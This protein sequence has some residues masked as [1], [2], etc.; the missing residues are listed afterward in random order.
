ME[1]VEIDEEV[2]V[3][4]SEWMGYMLLYEEAIEKVIEIAA[5]V[6]HLFEK[7]KARLEEAE[8]KWNDEKSAYI[9]M[10]GA[11]FSAYLNLAVHVLDKGKEMVRAYF[12]GENCS[13]QHFWT[14]KLYS[15]RGFKAWVEPRKLQSDK[16]ETPFR[17]ISENTVSY[18][19]VV[20]EWML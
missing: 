6:H 12:P 19:E 3:I 8:A 16:L 10:L 14:G 4:V 9:I 2:D 17:K 13:R 18:K 5:T 20:N 1:D 11:R 7:V 15:K